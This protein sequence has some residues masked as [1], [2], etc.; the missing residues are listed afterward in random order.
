MVSIHAGHDTHVP[1]F[2]T[3]KDDWE[4]IIWGHVWIGSICVLSDIWYILIQP[5]AL[6]SQIF[7]WTGETYLSY[8]LAAYLFLV[9]FFVDLFGSIVPLINREWM[10]EKK[11]LLFS[12][13]RYLL[14]SLGTEKKEF[15]FCLTC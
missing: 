4:D 7:V 15:L 5:F 3:Y 2:D 13:R 11:V 8:G 14:F 10:Q 12:V 9:S 6:A 1:I